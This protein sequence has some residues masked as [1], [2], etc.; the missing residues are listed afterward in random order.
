M[1]MTFRLEN[2]S[3]R[4]SSEAAR[5]ARARQI[6]HREKAANDDVRIDRGIIESLEQVL[7]KIQQMGATQLA[8]VVQLQLSEAP[9]R[10]FKNVIKNINQIRQQWLASLDISSSD[11]EETTDNSNDLT[12]HVPTASKMDIDYIIS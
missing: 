9:E 2:S 6:V 5:L 8:S 7:L 11:G 10:A 12:S 4:T 3:L 1:Y